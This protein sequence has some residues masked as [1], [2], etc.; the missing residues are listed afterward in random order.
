M[1]RAEQRNWDLPPLHFGFHNEE[2]QHHVCPFNLARGKV[3]HQHGNITRGSPQVRI[4][5]GSSRRWRRHVFVYIVLMV[6]TVPRCG[7]ITVL[8]EDR[9]L[10]VSGRGQQKSKK[11]LI[12][13]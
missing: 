7:V 13:R 4:S 2:R 3:Y 1:K 11:I 12:K 5:C 9:S 6:P 8:A 10:N